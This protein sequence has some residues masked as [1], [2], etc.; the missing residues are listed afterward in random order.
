M[1]VA[2]L[3]CTGLRGDRTTAAAALGAVH[4]LFGLGI[5]VGLLLTG[6]D[7]EILWMGMVVKG[8]AADGRNAHRLQIGTLV[9]GIIDACVLRFAFRP[10]EGQSGDDGGGDEGEQEAGRS[11]AGTKFGGLEIRER[12]KMMMPTDSKSSQAFPPPASCSTI[13]GALFAF[14]YQATTVLVPA[15][16][17]SNVGHSRDR[18]PLGSIHTTLSFQGSLAFGQLVLFLFGPRLGER[19]IVTGALVLVSIA[20]GLVWLVLN[21]TEYAVPVA[22]F[23]GLLLAPVYPCAL[24]GFLQNLSERERVSGVGIITG[25][26]NSGLATALLLAGLVE[27]WIS[28]LAL[29][30]I[31]AGIIIVMLLCWH[32]T[33]SAAGQASELSRL[34]SSN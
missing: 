10:P 16:I 29:Q 24:A 17:I 3:L 30:L 11:L 22:V 4:G 5:A 34:S 33:L 15:W 1:T 20:H 12:T 7:M 13:L 27:D 14:T 2:N 23:T 9:L 32:R 31:S 6:P 21:D 19:R 25:F 28:P 8:S 18:N 26:A